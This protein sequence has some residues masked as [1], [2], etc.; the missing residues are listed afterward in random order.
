M[1]ASQACLRILLLWVGP[2][3]TLLL[4]TDSLLLSATAGSS[5]VATGVD[6]FRQRRRCLPFPIFLLLVY[7]LQTS[8]L[9]ALP[10]DPGSAGGNLV[11]AFGQE[12]HPPSDAAQGVGPP[13]RTM[14]VVIAAH[15]EHKYMKRT[16]DSIYGS[17]P[18]E[19]LVEIIIVD[20]ASSPPL[21]SGLADYPQV[22]LLRHEQR[23]GLI[24]SKTEGGNIAT[25]DMIM[26][27]DGHVKP[28][29]NWWKP[30]LRHMNNNYKRLVV[31]I[32]PILNPDTWEPNLH[33]VGIKMMFDWTLFFQWFENGDD[34]VPCMSGGLFGITRRWWHESGEYDYGMS[35][36]G[37][38]NIEQSIRVW[39]CGGEI[40][41]ARDSTVSHV[42]RPSFPYRINNTEIY[43]NKVR[44]VEVWFDEFKEAYYQADPAARQFTRFAGNLSERFALKRRLQCKPFQWYVDK[45][46][47][48]FADKHMLPEDV[49]LFRDR[50]TGRCLELAEGDK[51]VVEADCVPP[52]P[53]QQWTFA[54]EGT[55]FRNVISNKCFDA[56]AGVFEKDGSN[57]FLFHCTASNVQ[58]VW[59][60]QRG[61]ISW[62]GY[63]V[64]GAAQGHLKLAKCQDFLQRSGDFEMYARRNVTG[65]GV[66]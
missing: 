49:F 47:K 16:L 13:I 15:N 25:G 7:A 30:I 60:L 61:Q 9:A 54:N 44:T 4:S 46:K 39:L 35:M 50:Q 29:P 14:S 64:Q 59:N 51:H 33:A 1:A 21:K 43:I 42:F 8:S 28:E 2:L 23:R 22:K 57:V 62:Q 48:V 52:S 37:A 65:P 40:Y 36:W 10:R 19:V 45:F 17:T 26:F 3:V 53:R 18:P 6:V 27:L 34:L 31:P 12:T 38:E 20:D 56:N 55:G 63:C 66:L 58:Q 24:K 5:I 32:I 41:V 11:R